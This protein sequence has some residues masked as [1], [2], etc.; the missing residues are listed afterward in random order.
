MP[1]S[2]VLSAALIRPFPDV[3]ATPYVV[4]VGVDHVPSPRRY[5]PCLP[6]AG[7]GTRPDPPAA[8]AVAALNVE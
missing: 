2:F 1:S 6:A 7:A 8:L 4:L 3:V 5:C